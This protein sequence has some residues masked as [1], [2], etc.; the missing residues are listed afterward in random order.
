MTTVKIN[1]S[2]AQFFNI[3]WSGERSKSKLKLS[4]YS[5][6][7]PIVNGSTCQLGKLHR[8]YKSDIDQEL[9]SSLVISK[10]IFSK[11]RKNKELDL[12]DIYEFRLLKKYFK[13]LSVRRILIAGYDVLIEGCLEKSN[14]QNINQLGKYLIQLDKES[15]K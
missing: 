6:L 8:T 4:S 15:N 9:L 10:F 3:K 5:D 13:V 14:D 11:L 2:D 7:Y 12:D 1:L